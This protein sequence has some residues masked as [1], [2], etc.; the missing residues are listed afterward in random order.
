MTEPGIEGAPSGAP[1]PHK[2]PTGAQ[3]AEGLRRLRERH[4]AVLHEAMESLDYRSRR[5]LELRYGLN[6]EQPRTLDEVGR[7]F[8]VTRERVRQIEIK[9]FENVEAA[10]EA[11]VQEREALPGRVADLERRTTGLEEIVVTLGRLVLE[12]Q[13]PAQDASAPIYELELSVRVYNLLKRAGIQT[14]DELVE[15]SDDELYAIPMFGRTCLREVHEALAA[16][17]KGAQR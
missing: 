11:A 5:I 1:T 3:R 2:H 16:R 4:A 8:N 15:R 17:R 12:R 7:T 10:V 6:G 9:A 13:A 14:V